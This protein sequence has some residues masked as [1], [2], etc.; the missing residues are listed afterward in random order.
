MRKILL[1]LII[2]GITLIATA[3]GEKEEYGLCIISSEGAA[4]VNGDMF[5]LMGRSLQLQ[6]LS[7]IRV[8]PA[9]S[10]KS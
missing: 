8:P 6:S 7:R 10:L 2:A 5:Y 1:P 9:N 3:S 4:D